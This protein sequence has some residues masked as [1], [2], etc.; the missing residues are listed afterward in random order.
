MTERI[1]VTGA[2][3]FVGRHLVAALAG[4]GNDV[5][6]ASRNPASVGSQRR[7]ELVR[8]PDLAQGIDWAPLLRDVAH[9][10]HLAAI[11]H[12][13]AALS[14]E[15][16][17][18]VNHLAVTELA[19]AAS[20]A[21]VKRLVFISSIASQSGSAAAHALSETDEPRPTTAYGRSKLAAEAALRDSGVAHTILRP[22]LV[23]GP[24]PPGN[25]R[26]LMRLAATRWPLP[27]AALTGRR[28]LLSVDNLIGAIQLAMTSPA[29]RD[30]TYVIADL[31]ALTLPEIIAA[32]R[33]ALGRPPGLFPLPPAL[34]AN[35]LRLIGRHDLWQR[36]GGSLV[37]D[38]AKLAAAG[39]RPTVDTRAGLTAMMQAE[40]DLAAR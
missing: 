15:V 18:R 1:L 8:V 6:A 29:T 13:G 23:Y 16:Y 12:R 27:F 32:L 35:A 14:D 37:V 17:D 24:N 5:V 19:A 20:R 10:V 2:S 34:L 28:S 21:G 26:A 7:V 4:A 36:L 31:H 30:E 3:G 39:W 11:A 40:A 22:V 33:A 9:V 25:M 38:P